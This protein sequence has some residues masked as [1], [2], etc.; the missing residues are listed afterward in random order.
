MGEWSITEI[1][2]PLGDGRMEYYRNEPH[3]FNHITM[4]HSLQI[5][6]FII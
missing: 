2:R 1:N 6:A 4:G 5:L 3:K